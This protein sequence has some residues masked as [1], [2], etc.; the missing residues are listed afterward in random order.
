[1]ERVEDEEAGHEVVAQVPPTSASERAQRAIAGRQL[2][3]PGSP[4]HTGGGGGPPPPPPPLVGAARGRPYIKNSLDYFC[5][6][7]NS[8]V[9]F[10][11]SLVFVE[12]SLV[13]LKIV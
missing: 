2:S 12:Y 4:H 5:I 9:Y 10:E 1:M 3:I 13:Y 6:F 11:N 8:L 7:K